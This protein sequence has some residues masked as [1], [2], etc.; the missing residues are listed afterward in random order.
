MN[1]CLQWK[2]PHIFSMYQNY[3]V[4]KHCY[5]ALFVKRSWIL[6]NEPHF[7]LIWPTQST[8]CQISRGQKLVCWW[9]EGVHLRL[10]KKS[11]MSFVFSQY[12]CACAAVVGLCRMRRSVC[13]MS[14]C[15][16]WWPQCHRCHKIWQTKI[17]PEET[18]I[19][20]KSVVKDTNL[21]H[22]LDMYWTKVH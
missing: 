10:S 22:T 13:W 21:K 17:Q 18:R 14:D 8:T 6:R 20:T 4:A 3:F 1:C 12:F 16:V 11:F 19:M 2:R 15:R 9:W 5:W 7:I